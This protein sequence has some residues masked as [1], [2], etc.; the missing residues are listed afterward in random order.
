[1]CVFLVNVTTQTKAQKQLIVFLFSLGKNWLTLRVVYSHSLIIKYNKWPLFPT[2]T[3]QITGGRWH[4]FHAHRCGCFRFSTAG[5]K[6]NQPRYVPRYQISP[7]AGRRGRDVGR[8]TTTQHPCPPSCGPMRSIPAAGGGLGWRG[9]L[10]PGD[11]ILGAVRD[12]DV[13]F[14]HA[15]TGH[16]SARSCV[17]GQGHCARLGARK[18]PLCYWTSW[19]LQ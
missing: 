15:R 16:W 12:E 6:G 14:V 3:D 7:H 17:H 4:R 2:E 8:C 10:H 19:V 5:W 13:C 11:Q 18:W 1:M 9:H